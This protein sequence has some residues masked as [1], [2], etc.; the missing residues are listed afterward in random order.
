MIRPKADTVGDI[1]LEEKKAEK[2]KKISIAEVDGQI[3]QP[4]A[5]ITL[6]ETVNDP[7]D[8]RVSKSDDWLHKK[9]MD[10][11]LTEKSEWKLE[12]VEKKLNHP[13]AGVQR[14]L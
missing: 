1:T 12:E 14:M 13:K 3:I 10:L 2:E 8:K 9:I 7:K 4:P 5:F 11:F 6:E